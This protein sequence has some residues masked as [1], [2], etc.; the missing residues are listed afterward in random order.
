MSVSVRTVVPR[1]LLNFAADSK[2]FHLNLYI[3]GALQYVGVF[4]SWTSLAWSFVS[5]ASALRNSNP[6]KAKM[7]T[8]S[9]ITMFFWRFFT[10]GGRVIA[11][12]L[13][14]SAFGAWATLVL[15]GAHLLV[16]ILWMLQQNSIYCSVETKDEE[17]NINV[18]E[19]PYK[20][21]FFR[22][23]TA[24]ILVF[25][26][27]NIAEGRTRLRALVYYTI[28]FAENLTMIVA[29]YLTASTKTHAW[30]HAP[31][32]VLVIFG[33]FV[34]IGLQV[35]YYKCCHPIYY[36][37]E[38]EH[39]TIPYWVPCDE[40]SLTG[41]QSVQG[42]RE[43]PPRDDDD[44]DD[45]FRDETRTPIYNPSSS[46]ASSVAD[47]NSLSGVYR[48]ATDDVLD[49][50]ESLGYLPNSTSRRE[51]P[52]AT[53][54][55]NEPPSAINGAPREQAKRDKKPQPRPRERSKERKPDEFVEKQTSANSPRT[56]ELRVKIPEP[57]PRERSRERTPDKR[58]PSA[59]RGKPRTG[60]MEEIPPARRER[61][62]EVKLAEHAKPVPQKRAA[63]P[64][65]SRAPPEGDF[66]EISEGRGAPKSPLRAVRAPDATPPGPSPFSSP[67][68]STPTRSPASTL[69]TTR[70]DS[71]ENLS[72]SEASQ[73]VSYKMTTV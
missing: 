50:N 52:R 16:M 2:Q 55:V 17:G 8:S 30:Y 63:T 15:I 71:D 54:R 39:V 23:M 51:V 25:T 6:G 60:R 20:E 72:T 70:A 29:W 40:L 47:R 22:A 13:F 33:F 68:H 56:K 5:F 36:S 11:L 37:K 58:S 65:R 42:T 66:G 41:P 43:A 67:E 46:R 4:T 28:V 31:A 7:Q 53:T 24:F 64:P 35:M 38:H 45:A 18:V 27:F 9:K 61:S 57:R 14:A 69:T 1:T 59:E 49:L 62:P 48:S 73:D 34:G 21:Y 44:D 3:S 10:V 12:A 26:F 19:H 32:I